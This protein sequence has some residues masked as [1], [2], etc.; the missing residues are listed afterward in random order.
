N[1]GV[2]ELVK[3]I[4]TQT[5]SGSVVKAENGQ[6][7]LNLGENSVTVGEQLNVMRK[8]EELIDPDTGIS[9]GSSD[10][11]L[12]SI[13]VIQVQ[14]QFSIARTLSMTGDAMRGDA[15][16]SQRLPPTIEYGDAW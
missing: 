1:K 2:F 4:G 10:T 11:M 13:E 3:Q 6:V 15:V 14:P 8:G 7:W 5:A 16:L 9:L 12:G